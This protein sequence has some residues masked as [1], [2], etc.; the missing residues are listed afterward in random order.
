[1]ELIN[2]L[3]YNLSDMGSKNSKTKINY[4]KSSTTI[5]SKGGGN[6]NS[7]LFEILSKP[8]CPRKI[9]NHLRIHPNTLNVIYEAPQDM[10]TSVIIERVSL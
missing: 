7:L 8:E 1:M 2:I 3:V 4:T 9:L 5:I 6:E 10:E